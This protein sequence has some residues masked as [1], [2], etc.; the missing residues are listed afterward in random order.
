MLG[1]EALA[2]ASVLIVGAGG[3][4]CPSSLY[5]AAAGVGRLGI[6]D[7]D[8]V[9]ACNLH[10]Q[11]A[12]REASAGAPKAHSLAAT[13]RAL[14]SSIVVVE[15][16]VLL[17][18]ENVFDLLSGYNVVVDAT[19]NVVTRY[20]LN[21]ACVIL[22]LPLVSGA[23]LRLDG[24][25]TTYN[26]R[27]PLAGAT[28]A[29]GEGSVEWRSPCYRCIFEEAPPAATV[30]SCDAGGV[31]G[32]I[33][34]MIG[35]LQ[36]LEVI[37]CLAYGAPNYAGKLLIFSGDTGA[38]RTLQLRGRRPDC[39]VCG[40]T[41]TIVRECMSD[42]RAFCHASAPNDKPVA[43][44]LLDDA[45]RITAEA[46]HAARQAAD[47]S[48]PLVIDVRSAAQTAIFEL[49]GSVAIPL[50]RLEESLNIVR[51][52]A[53]GEGAPRPIYCICRRGND[54]QRAVLLLERHAI[55]ASDVIGGLHAYAQ[56]FPEAGVPIY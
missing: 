14:N 11:V 8:T 44:H 26:W 29:S 46:F 16:A 28:G 30:T 39:A 42:Y 49:P 2:S 5:L 52:L 20:L 54:S 17:S 22:G 55:P 36:A 48:R 31:L 50:G 45:A 43:L 1:Q 33:P 56:A 24:Q 19:D 9:E 6:L 23:A 12:H 27:G 47:G 34:G 38:F 4:G 21:D 41:P 15:H 13:L 53:A 32:P 7:Y 35:T 37:K 25:L 3:L 51:A 18:V 40:D 10:R